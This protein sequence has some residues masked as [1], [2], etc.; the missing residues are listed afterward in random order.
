MVLPRV[1][2]TKIQRGPFKRWHQPWG[3]HHIHVASSQPIGSFHNLCSHPRKRDHERVD[4]CIEQTIRERMGCTWVSKGAPFAA[5]CLRCWWQVCKAW[6]SLKAFIL[7]RIGMS[8]L[9]GG[10]SGSGTPLAISITHKKDG[11]AFA[12]VKRWVPRQASIGRE[13]TPQCQSW[14]AT[15]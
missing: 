15:C 12:L 10:F 5:H 11:D 4:R 9:S 7:A 8:G 3:H 6:R 2:R 14:G 1:S 13:E